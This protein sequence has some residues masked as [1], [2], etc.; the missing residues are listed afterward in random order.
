M[1]EFIKKFCVTNRPIFSDLP[2]TVAIFVTCLTLL[3]QFRVMSAPLS[4]NW[5]H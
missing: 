4:K 3:V 2:L 1:S 5:M